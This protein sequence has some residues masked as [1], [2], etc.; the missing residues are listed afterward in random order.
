MGESEARKS[1]RRAKKSPTAAGPTVQANSVNDAA[2][3]RMVVS[4]GRTLGRARHGTGQGQ[5]RLWVDRQRPLA[6]A[7]QAEFD[8]AFAVRR[9]FCD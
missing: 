7:A 1:Q 6:S 5:A 4:A 9:H 8:R 2:L 3:A